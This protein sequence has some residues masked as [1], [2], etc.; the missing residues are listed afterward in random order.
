MPPCNAKVPLSTRDLTATIY[1]S[2]WDPSGATCKE[3]RINTVINIL[4][5]ILLKTC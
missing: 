3:I 1:L 4:K 2:L 5:L